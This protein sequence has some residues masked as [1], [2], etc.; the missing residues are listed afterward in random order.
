LEA[1]R[2][3]Y[4]V[5][6]GYGL[7]AQMVFCTYCDTEEYERSLHAELGSLPVELVDKYVWDA[8]HH[9]G[10]EVDFKHFVPRI[11][12]LLAKGEL[13]FADP[14][15]A[16]GRLAKASWRQWPADER[17]SVEAV[18]DGIWDDVMRL[19]EPPVD[20]DSLVCGL[21]LAFGGVPPQVRAWLSDERPLAVQRLV[22]FVLANGD[23]LPEARL[24]DPWWKDDPEAMAA[25]AAWVLSAGPTAR[26]ADAR[27]ARLVDVATASRA[28]EILIGGGA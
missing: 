16:I 7:P 19:E 13:P 23:E 1:I 8:M 22:Q 10:D 25:V 2:R 17:E 3:L 6:S 28:I 14:E 9:T 4:G 15:M 27:E 26:L 21:G 5:F 24:G 18:L 11:Y 20:I 12:E